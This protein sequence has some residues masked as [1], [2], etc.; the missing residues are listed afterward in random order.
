MTETGSAPAKKRPHRWRRR[1]VVAL[2]SLLAVAV[3]FRIALALLLPAVMNRVAHLYK[4]QCHYD[5]LDLSLTGGTAA[6]WGFQLVPIEGGDPVLRADYLQGDISVLALLR[7]RLVVYRAAADG[8][9]A[10]FERQADGRIPLLDRFASSGSAQSQPKTSAPTTQPA[11]LDLQPPL[12]IDALR[13]E[14]VRA[15]VRDLA[16]QPNIDARL[17]LDLRVSNLATP[18]EPTRFELDFSSD[19]F[20]DSL[21]IY[22]SATG[23]PKQIWASLH[24]LMRGLHL[25]PA[26]GYLS[27]LGM[28]AVADD[29][30]AAAD[31]QLTASVGPNPGDGIGGTLSF[32][33]ARLTSDGR[34]AAAL[35]SLSLGIDSLTP[36]ALKLGNLAITGVRCEAT[37][38]P[39]GALAMAG[40]EIGHAPASSP[41]PQVSP[42]P[43]SRVPTPASSSPIQLS[44]NQMT[45]S[46]LHMN[47]TDQSLSPSV[48]LS[49]DSTGFEIDKVDS[50]HPDSPAKFSMGFTA[51][52]MVRAININ[53][54]IS[55]F[56]ADKSFKLAASADG[57]TLSAAQP[58]LNTAGFA[59]EWKDGHFSVDADGN[60]SLDPGGLTASARLSNLLLA[61]G[62]EEFLAIDHAGV[63]GVGIDSQTRTLRVDGID[64][65]GPGIHARRDADGNLHLFGFKTVPAAIVP[66]APAAPSDNE[67]AAPP[68]APAP[69]DHIQLKH[70]AWNNVHVD[71]KDDSVSPPADLSISD[72][73][74]S[75]T[76]LAI[77]LKPTS[78]PP[79]T[80][81]IL[82][83]LQAPNLASRLSFEADVTPAWDKTQCDFKIRGEGLHGDALA[84]Y[85]RPLGIE[86]TLKNGS[87]ELHGTAKLDQTAETP[88]VSLAMDHL[89][90]RDGSE[91]LIS[92]GAV[93]VDS[94]S[95]AA[96]KISVDSIAVTSP[97]ARVVRRLDGGVET[98]GLHFIARPPAKS[99]VQ[100]A[101]PPIID[102]PPAPS[103]SVDANVHSLTLSDLAVDWIDRAAT[104][105]VQTTIR[106][107]AQLADFNFSDHPY[108]A[109][110]HAQAS[111]D[112]CMDAMNVAGTLAI[113][114]SAQSMRLNFD[115][116]GVRAG[117]MTAYLPSG[118]H[119]RLKNGSIHMSVA[120]DVSE[121]P[122]GGQVVEIGVS[123]FN[124]HDEFNA[125]YLQFDTFHLKAPRLD[126]AAKV[127]SIDD[128]TLTGLETGAQKTDSGLN[129]L[130]LEFG[131]SSPQPPSPPSNPTPA[132]PT[133]ES[134]ST[135]Q[136]SNNDILRQI[137]SEREKFP[138]VKLANLNLSI[139]KFTMTDATHPQAS[140]IVV[141]NLQIKN[142]QP[143]AL[144]GRDPE[145]N[146]PAEIT[147]TGRIDPI[148]DQL[149]I[150]AKAAPFLR[151]K[152]LDVDVK[153]SGIHGAGLT[154]IAPQ[155]ASTIDGAAMTDGQFT[156]SLQAAL[157]LQTNLPTDFDLAHGGKL[158]FSVAKTEFRDSPVGPVLCGVGEIRS[159]GVILSPN[160]TAIEFKELEIDNLIGR[161][162]R[163][164]DGIHALGL[165]IKM[166]TTRPTQTADAPPVAN[167]QDDPPPTITPNPY[168]PPTVKID[169]LLIS[170]ID[171]R[172]ED[173]TCQPHAVI[174]IN[175][176]DVEVTNLTNRPT[177]G[178]QPIRFNLLA[179]A[180]KVSVPGREG[181][182]DENRELF[183]QIA[184][185]GEI[186]MVP[187]PKGW[188]KLSLSG[189]ELLGVRGLAHEERITVGGGTFDGDVDLRFAGDGTID[190]STRLVLT[191]LSLSEPP[192]GFISHTLR[193]PAS[194]DIV[195]AALQDQD[196]SITVP[197]NIPIH[198]GQFS[199]ASVLGA[200]VG[201]LAEI[202]TTALASAPLKLAGLLLG[203]KQN[204]AEPPVRISFAAGYADVSPDQF[205]RLKALSEQLR[206]DDSL[207]VTL[208]CDAGR[209][210]VWLAG[211]RVNPGV[212]D[213][214]VLAAAF[215]RRRDALLAAHLDAASQ[216]RALLASSDTA[217][218]DAAIQRLRTI[219]REL[220]YTENELDHAYDLLR[221]GADRQALRRTRAATLAIARSRLQ[222][223]RDYLI[224]YGRHALDPSRISQSNPQFVE[225][226]QNQDGS[227]TITIVKGK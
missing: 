115:A 217:D 40:I 53:G 205:P 73:G 48:V 214:A 226:P 15:R 160:L 159:D 141:S 67:S 4:L 114:P 169:R 164:S 8:V 177:A 208:R 113:S 176:L 155:L 55:P 191:D 81:K 211:R 128:L 36:G 98:A 106:A 31:G 72:A 52:G 20:L 196:G 220:A 120:G 6:M 84:S 197:L 132:A 29:I 121:N 33:N 180:D 22:G 103:P 147:V 223:I 44:L 90:Y 154:A 194:L 136:P 179:S 99:P 150:D 12:R 146:P 219:D 142:T 110:L 182:A 1:G 145:S 124:Y 186:A 80:G 96:G 27:V 102:P 203:S 129:L 57:I 50:L 218:A 125:P 16:V 79:H 86:P 195:I 170:G 23:N 91:S 202:V 173:E 190:T 200:G 156:T 74:V 34:E 163:E 175:G 127:V 149:M 134:S 26:Q 39:D 108:P 216:V 158:D 85:L 68:A 100:V 41:Q 152:T 3:I 13:L 151:Q 153:I 93:H 111:V 188:A 213:A 183:S 54:E 131:K 71:L 117:P 69:F 137:A 225:S 61:D 122:L 30:N 94:V 45:L 70:F 227:V 24:L 82:A 49:L 172:V 88:R 51:P 206:K 21:Q 201:A 135:S 221:P 189:F 5:R 166:P 112:G 10:T 181:S 123:D 66:P 28:R 63:N 56:A 60:I 130:G 144:L 107:Q 210:D 18:G 187:Q 38:N 42:A 198:Q 17:S 119:S 46:G 64:I 83:W 116:S 59:S 95:T 77:H 92:V 171:C 215:E 78:E 167:I 143:L 178:D 2:I 11:P 9:D 138:L 109:Q 65:S 7:G 204:A 47:F 133:M 89:D 148:A 212:E 162:R 76:D 184:G 222:T 174:P 105:T 161:A 193:L 140:P 87:L 32:T 35:D 199:T 139:R 43:G 157:K 185:S 37:R 101:G 62:P 58:Y 165:I 97:H 14:H 25:K 75:A 207:R 192:N 19:P 168:P 224:G 118:I 104:P 126:P 209:D